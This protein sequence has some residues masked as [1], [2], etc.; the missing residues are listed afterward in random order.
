MTS[1]F[2]HMSFDSYHGGEDPVSS[3]LLL[4]DTILSTPLKN[5]TIVK[6]LD[7]GLKER[8]TVKVVEYHHGLKSIHED[9]RL[10][11]VIT[12][13]AHLINLHEGRESIECELKSMKESKNPK[14][15]SLVWELISKTVTSL[16]VKTNEF[17]LALIS[18]EKLR[19]DRIKN[20]MQD[21]YKDVKEKCHSDHLKMNVFFYH[22]IMKVNKAVLDN[23]QSYTNLLAQLKMELVC[24]FSKWHDTWEL[25]L[26]SWRD[27][28]T[29]Q[30]IEK[31]EK[32]SQDK[33]F[34]VPEEVEKA[35]DVAFHTLDWIQENVMEVCNHLAARMPV[36]LE[37]CVL[38]FDRIESMLTS[39]NV[40]VHRF[41]DHSDF[42]FQQKFKEIM[43]HVGDMRGYLTSKFVFG[44][45]K[46]VDLFEYS[47]YCICQEFEKNINRTQQKLVTTMTD[48]IHQKEKFCETVKVFTIGIA[49]SWSSNSEGFKQ[50]RGTFSATVDGIQKLHANK[51]SWLE[52]ALDKSSEIMTE[53]K[54]I[55][56]L[57]KRMGV[58]EV[59]LRKIENEYQDHTIVMKGQARD[60]KE[61]WKFSC[62]TFKEKILKLLQVKPLDSEN[63]KEAY[64]TEAKVHLFSINKDDFYRVIDKSETDDVQTFKNRVTKSVVKELLTHINSLKGEMEA[65]ISAIKNQC[66]VDAGMRQDIHQPRLQDIN[67]RIYAAR[68]KE[69]KSFKMECEKFWD[70]VTCSEKRYTEMFEKLQSDITSSVSSYNDYMSS[71]KKD[72]DMAKSSSDLVQ[73]LPLIEDQ[74]SH[75]KTFLDEII[76]NF[77][78]ELSDH[79][80]DI[81][82]KHL[83][84]MK[85]S[86]DNN[87]KIS[88]HLKIQNENE[89]FIEL[90]GEMENKAEE[91]REK[92]VNIHDTRSQTLAYYKHSIFCLFYLER[93]STILKIC[94]LGVKLDAAACSKDLIKLENQ[95]KKFCRQIDS[96][97]SGGDI[98]DFIDQFEG[99]YKFAKE[100][101]NK[102]NFSSGIG[103]D[104]DHCVSMDRL[105]RRY[106]KFGEG[107]SRSIDSAFLKDIIS[108]A[109]KSGETE[110]SGKQNKSEQNWRVSRYPIVK[111]YAGNRLTRA[112][113]GV[114]VKGDVAP[115]KPSSSKAMNKKRSRIA[116]TL[117]E[118]SFWIKI[119]DPLK[120]QKSQEEH[121]AIMRSACAKLRERSKSGYGRRLSSRGGLPGLE[122]F[123]AKSEPGSP[124]S[125]TPV[126]PSIVENQPKKEPLKKKPKKKPEKE[127][128]PVAKA[129]SAEQCDM[130][131]TLQMIRT[132]EFLFPTRSTATSTSSSA[133]HYLLYVYDFLKTPDETMKRMLF[134]PSQFFSLRPRKYDHAVA[135]KQIA[136]LS[137]KTKFNIRHAFEDYVLM[138]EVFYRQKNADIPNK[139]I[140]KD[141]DI[142]TKNMEADLQKYLDKILKF[143]EESVETMKGFIYELNIC[144]DK[145]ISFAFRSVSL[146]FDEE[147]RQWSM[148]CHEVC[149]ELLKTQSEENDKLFGRLSPHLAHPNQHSQLDQLDNLAKIMVRCHIDDISVHHTQHA[150]TLDELHSNTLARISNNKEAMYNLADVTIHPELVKRITRY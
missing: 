85:Y 78:K 56:M 134:E 84:L 69:I 35:K 32:L 126:L 12:S 23:Y 138:S 73:L 18:I 9:I 115:V 5:S 137:E 72:M 128:K 114:G 140:P 93:K 6:R 13:Q 3:V 51:L 40:V 50:I 148:K 141:V 99:I 48:N 47:V 34:L 55:K 94:R 127:R 36:D 90:T 105:N 7:D 110:E 57:D 77:H 101:T 16:F 104:L 22:E 46:S 102:F 103:D 19:L 135:A 120:K 67:N 54:T 80:E 38:P 106:R 119:I 42:I 86:E 108:T 65:F 62:N 87:L 122:A 145:F 139:E 1:E 142:A 24:N 92:S 121:N 71:L 100:V 79:K 63:L 124:R 25:L 66:Q 111:Q 82:K 4:P 146:R 61:S 60:M 130:E 26:F 147:T 133:D 109:Q 88:N 116:S 144:Q 52:R 143:N 30:N 8:Y 44:G 17:G 27:I 15:F 59:N 136:S 91:E 21:H 33:R 81:T 41:Q 97:D 74:Q 31:I 45:D 20:H 2:L 58:V 37:T 118:K 95:I 149:G 96:E 49:R 112:R 89:E 83:K 150:K 29:T 39:C 107:S 75:N 98:E 70:E 14:D 28:L 113:Y 11:L 125:S 53:S 43:G 131:E 10:Q 129:R 123:M 117:P 64:W 132:A 68:K 76:D